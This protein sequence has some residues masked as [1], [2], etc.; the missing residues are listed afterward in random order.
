MQ[1]F[2]DFLKRAG[3]QPLT[4]PAES[5]DRADIERKLGDLE[6]VFGDYIE[7][8]RELE[9]EAA[10]ETAETEEGADHEAQ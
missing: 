5:R 7:D 4:A 10:D 6:A 3:Y 1:N 8:A 9:T 2:N